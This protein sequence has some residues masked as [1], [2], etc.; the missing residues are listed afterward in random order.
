MAGCNEES[1]LLFYFP[2][3]PININI[4]SRA[5]DLLLAPEYNANFKEHLSYSI[6][7]LRTVITRH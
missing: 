2:F 7:L 5:R 1:A 6:A 3:L 4:G